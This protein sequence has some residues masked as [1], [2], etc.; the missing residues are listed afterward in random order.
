MG[1]PPAASALL[2]SP[3]AHCLL[4]YRMERRPAKDVD[5]RHCSLQWPCRLL[6]HPPPS[7]S[8]V[9]GHTF[10]DGA[11]RASL[12]KPGLD[13]SDAAAGRRCAKRREPLAQ[14]LFL[15]AGSGGTSWARPG[16]SPAGTA[17]LPLNSPARVMVL[18]LLLL[19]L[20]FSHIRSHQTQHYV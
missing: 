18:F 7:S 5:C 16:G 13:A 15:W 20:V 6:A 4:L 1:M 8:S 14:P 2:V 19:L 10:D 9:P 17:F 11:C 3:A 12:A